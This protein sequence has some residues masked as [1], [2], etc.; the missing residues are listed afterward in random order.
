VAEILRVLHRIGGRDV[1][2][3]AADLEVV[4]P[5]SEQCVGVFA[6]ADEA[7][8]QAAVAAARTAF[9]SSGWAEDPGPGR[10]QA[11]RG[12]AADLRAHADEL[13]RLQVTETGVP[14]GTALRQVAAAADWFDYYADFITTEAGHSYRQT[15]NAEVL[16]GREPVGVCALFSPWNVP[17][18]LSAIKLAPA[19]AAGNAVVLK[20]SELTPRCV[21]RLVDIV[22]AHLPTGLLNCVNGLGPLTGAA[23]AAADGV[24]M[25]SFTGGS[26]GGRAV[27]ERAAQRP[28]P[29]VTELGGK[30]ATLV[31]AD[32]DID[33]AVAGS[34]RAAYGN[35]GQACLA[36]SRILV[37]EALF[38]RF[39]EAFRAAAAALRIGHPM[40]ERTDVGPLITAR[41]R[42][43]V[44]AYCD[45]TPRFGDEVLFGGQATAVG[46]C[47]HYM[48]PAGVRVNHPATSRVW[49]EEIF[50]PVVALATFASEDESVAL[51]NDSAHGLAG[52]VWTRDVGR[53]LRVARRLRT[54]SVIVN[55]SFVRELNA[56]FG[57]FKASGVGREGGAHSWANVT[58]AKTII[59][60]N[61]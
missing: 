58:Q 42:S 26:A 41:H 10:R 20:P 49:R 37:E 38:D 23:L 60:V 24:D 35:N 12:A 44:L 15:A 25:I 46:G 16:V 13:A 18:A 31:F 48:T 3:A 19:L 54:G 6:Q 36:G 14:W 53:A 52:Y 17:L 30:S 43:R 34:L 40:D 55:Q 4:D 45:E 39:I 22:E 32:C 56:P 9:E 47:G 8:V 21:R 61:D 7:Q 28:I 29:C 50:G 33:R 11:L 51:A 59:L 1:A 27:A 57:G 5:A 2:G